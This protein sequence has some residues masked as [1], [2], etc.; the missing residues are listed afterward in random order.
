MQVAASELGIGE[1]RPL[2]VTGGLTFGGGPLNNYVMHAIARTA[3][4][5]RER[6][7]EIGLVTSNGGFITKHA[8]GVYSTEPPARPFR[9][10]EPQD[11][12]DATPTREVA[13]DYAGDVEIESYTVMF[14]TDGPTVG[15]AALRLDDGR[16]GWGNTEDPDVLASMISEEFCGRRAKLAADGSL[17]F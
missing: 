5:L 6:P 16:R 2:T 1:D 17:T 11:E 12:I 3:E 7:G 10:A 4:V 9:A 15:L 8:F 13:V 14:G